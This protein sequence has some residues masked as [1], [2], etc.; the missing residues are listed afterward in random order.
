MTNN[1]TLNAI[2]AAVDNMANAHGIPNAFS[3]AELAQIS[4]VDRLIVGQV[5][6]H[7]LIRV[8][9]RIAH[10][11]CRLSLRAGPGRTVYVAIDTAD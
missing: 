11:D 4:G 1:K 6:R 9:A 8:N 5:A 2:A 3:C 7:D 10:T